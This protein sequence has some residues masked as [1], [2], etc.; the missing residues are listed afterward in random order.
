MNDAKTMKFKND[1]DSISGEFYELVMKDVVIF[2]H[3]NFKNESIKRQFYFLQPES[4]CEADKEAVSKKKSLLNLIS[5]VIPAA[6][7]CRYGVPASSCTGKNL[8]SVEGD[9]GVQSELNYYTAI[10]NAEAL[11]YYWKEV[12]EQTGCKISPIYREYTKLKMQIAADENK[13][14]KASSLSSYEDDNIAK[15][16]EVVWEEVKPLY[17]HFHAFVRRRLY[18]KYGDALIDLEGPIPAHLLGNMYAQDWT[19]LGIVA[20]AEAPSGVP[21]PEKLVEKGFDSHAIL[22]R[23]EDFF[24]S[25]GLE[26]MTEKFWT[27][28]MFDRPR[29]GRIVDCHGSAYD[30]HFNDYRLKIC[31]VGN[32][33]DFVLIYHEMGHVQY[34]MC[35][36]DLPRP[37][38]SGANDAFHEAVGDTMG[39]AIFTQSHLERFGLWEQPEDP[40]TV[41][42]IEN[43]L[44]MRTA[45]H[46]L[47]QIPYSYLIDSW[48]W[49]FLT[50]E[51][52]LDRMNEKYWELRRSLQGI[53]PPNNE[54]RP[55]PYYLDGAAKF[56]VAGDRIYVN[57]YVSM[58]HQFQFFEALCRAASEYDPDSPLSAPLHQCDF[59]GSK[60]AGKLLQEGLRIGSL[61]HWKLVLKKMTGYDGLSLQP[62]LHY[63]EPLRV[64]LLHQNMLEGNCVGW[65][66]EDCTDHV[67]KLAKEYL[68]YY[69]T[70][71]KKFVE[72]GR[73][74]FQGFLKWEAREYTDLV[75]PYLREGILSRLL[76]PPLK[77]QFLKIEANSK[78]NVFVLFLKKLKCSFE[79]TVDV[80]M[81]AASCAEVDP[82]RGVSEKIMMGQLAHIGTGCFDLILDAEKCKHGIELPSMGGV[83]GVGGMFF[84]PGGISPAG[85]SPQMTPFAS[86]ATPGYGSVWSPGLGSG[87]TPGGPAFSPS[88]SSDASGMSPAW[89]PQPGSPGSPAP[90]SPYIPS[91][92]GAMSPSYSP[93]SPFGGTSPNAPGTPS[94]SPTSP[95][96]SPTSP[97]FNPASPSYSPTSPGYS[98]TSPSY[99]PTSPSYSPTSPSYSPT[100][101]SY[102]PTSPSYSPTSP[103]YSP[104]SPSYSPTSPSYSPTSPSYSPTSPSYS[105]T[106]P[107]YSPTSPSYSPTSPSY[108][109]TSPSYSP[110]SPS[111]S[112]TSPSYSPTS[113]SYAP[114]S[115]TYSPSSPGYSPQSP[116]YSPSS[117][118][119]SPTSPSYSPAS[120]SYSPGSPTYTPT[121]PKYSPSSPQYSP[122]SPKYSPSS[123][124]YSPTS[125]SYS[126][127]SPTYSP[128]SP[129][130]SPTSPTYSPTSP[131]YSPTS[132]TYSDDDP[133][134]RKKK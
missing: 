13:D 77:R 49:S 35:Y 78:M 22:L 94:Y 20:F 104:T 99:S 47:P 58:V 19:P 128:T 89:S 127:S 38:R 61:K 76:S 125:P 14:L 5:G 103:S 100:S 9:E 60:E 4:H 71:K 48:R 55:D 43:N 75:K 112:P 36:R 25:I 110:T 66:S 106:S 30:L 54:P 85:M 32:M 69:V 31:P 92:A 8:L 120:P 34:F 105:P 40:E 70:K 15:Q 121:S 96:Y 123:P 53:V 24:K 132:P 52:P 21:K 12:R 115:P 80:L 17:Q 6:R 79:E 86:G 82:L 46:K 42:K 131:T 16:L 51:T 7:I 59:Y 109:P 23:A 129:S 87:M 93:S 133:V 50:G 119:Y 26:P 122:S 29:D 41:T 10:G 33:H 39:L 130:Y 11:E 107:S 3:K 97:T 27:K 113:P 73:S 57:Y 62:F 98:P 90:M 67:N 111:Y 45:L 118:K 108:S 2:N 44:L 18:N 124:S 84:G 88:G 63:F 102:S 37:L 126:P 114:T 1:I 116:S 28:S 56:H 83:A 81:E 72:L 117:P 68:D 91:P 95:G 101:P 134:P 65:E 64:F 74:G